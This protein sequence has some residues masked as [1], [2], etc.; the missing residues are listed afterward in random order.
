M[1]QIVFLSFMAYGVAALPAAGSDDA[2]PK[3]VISNR[4]YTGNGCPAGTVSSSTSPMDP[5]TGFLYLT[6]AFDKLMPFT[7]PGT[8]VKDHTK[9]CEITF[10]MTVPEGWKLRVNQNGTVFGGYLQI[11]PQDTAVVRVEYVVSREN[12][13]VGLSFSFSFFSL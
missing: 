6:H 12:P 2:P 3:P 9:K 4:A 5:N 7:G 8:S 11:F 13:S 10:N 1:K